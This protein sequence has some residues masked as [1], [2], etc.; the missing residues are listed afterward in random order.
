[1]K[2][3][4]VLGAAVAAMLVMS[5]AASALTSQFFVGGAPDDLLVQITLDDADTPGEIKVTA[6]VITNG[7]NPNTGDLRGIFFHVGDESLLAGLSATGADVTDQQFSANAVSDLG[8]GANM[9]GAAGSPFD[10]GIEIGTQGIGTDDIQMTMFFLSHNS[11]SLDLSLFLDPPQLFGVRATSVGEPGSNR[12]GSV[13]LT[14]PPGDE[15]IPE[16]VTAG[17]ALLGLGAL[18]YATRRRRPA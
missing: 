13:K 7:G 16:P 4:F 10:G 5:S 9:N 18:G 15:I 2:R 3:T 12:S 6:E 11:E 17:L 8:N 1:M 14:D